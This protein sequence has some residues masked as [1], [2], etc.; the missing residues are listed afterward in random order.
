[1]LNHCRRNVRACHPSSSD[2]THHKRFAYEQPTCCIRREH[3]KARGQK[4]LY[5]TSPKRFCALLRRRLLLRIHRLFDLYRLRSCSKILSV[6]AF[7][8]SLQASI[9]FLVNRKVGKITKKVT[10]IPFTL[11]RWDAN[12]HKN[13]ELLE[14]AV[15]FTANLKLLQDLSWPCIAQEGS[16]YPSISINLVSF[17]PNITL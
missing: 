12:C 13:Y 14:D 3:V 4:Y 9:D 16:K 11:G 15:Y 6:F 10:I 1:M 5:P 7:E 2:I 17:A 8:N